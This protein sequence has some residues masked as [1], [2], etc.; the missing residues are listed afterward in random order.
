M[1]GWDFIIEGWLTKEWRTRQAQ[2]QLAHQQRSSVQ[3]WV[4]ALIFKLW[5]VAWDLWEHRNGVEHAHDQEI[6]HIQLNSKIDYEIEQYTF[7]EYS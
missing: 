5:E 2:F 4:S 1:I 6:L 3:R 7:G